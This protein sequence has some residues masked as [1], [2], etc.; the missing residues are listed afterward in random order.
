MAYKLSLE[1]QESMKF[2]EDNAGATFPDDS[3]EGDKMQ[4]ARTEEDDELIPWREVPERVWLRIVNHRNATTKRGVVKIVTLQKR[5]GSIIRA[6]TSPYITKCVDTTIAYH[7]N[8]DIVRDETHLYIKSLGKEPCS[9][10]DDTKSF[11]NVQLKH[12]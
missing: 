8:K 2:P 5:D 3:L 7:A 6:W 10:D 4:V 12:F 1:E 9:L 11:F